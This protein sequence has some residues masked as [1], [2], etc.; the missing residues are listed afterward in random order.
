MNIGFEGEYFNP[1]KEVTIG[2]LNEVLLKV[3]YGFDA[4]QDANA[5]KPITKE[6]LAQSFITKLGLDKISG[7]KD[8]YQTG[9][10]DEKNISSKYLGAVALAKGLGLMEA[11]S[12]NMYYP[13]NKVTRVE[14]VHLILKFIDVQRNKEMY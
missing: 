8:I 2:E 12:N 14:A 5:N 13:S 9:F 10:A 1:D 4:E 6:E 7:I 11:D 3:G